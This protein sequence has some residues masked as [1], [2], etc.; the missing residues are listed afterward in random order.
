[1]EVKAD[2]LINAIR[3]RLGILTDAS[4]ARYEEIWNKLKDPDDLVTR[5]QAD[6]IG[7]FMNELIE[8]VVRYKLDLPVQGMTS[9]EV[10]QFKSLWAV[11]GPWLTDDPG[12][13][14]ARLTG[15]LRKA[16][17]EPKQPPSVPA[18]GSTSPSA[19]TVAAAPVM[20]GVPTPVRALVSRSP[21]PSTLPDRRCEPKPVAVA[22]AAPQSPGGDMQPRPANSQWV[23]R[24]VPA[25]EP[26]A[27]SVSAAA[28][29]IT[30]EHYGLL[31][32]RVRGKKHKHEGTN[33]DDWFEIETSGDWALVAVA[34]GAGSYKYSRIGARV[35]CERAIEVLREGLSLLHLPERP[36]ADGLTARD[37]DGVILDPD[38]AAIQSI[39]H[40]AV[41][42][43][44][45]AVD[46][47][48]VALGGELAQAITPNDLSATLLLAV[49]TTLLVGGQRQSL[50]VACQIGD[51]VIA[52]VWAD[53]AVTLLGQAD[54]G[55]YSGETEF[56]TS[57]RLREAAN[58]PRR[59]FA[60]VGA[61][62]AIL[63]MTDGVGD[64]YFPPD[65][66]MARLYADLVQNGILRTGGRA[67]PV[68]PPP[69]SSVDAADGRLDSHVQAPTTDGPERAE[70]ASPEERLRRWLDAYH[71]RGSFDDRTLVVLDRE[72]G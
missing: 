57:R 45:A 61:P 67:G 1:M 17:E 46:N 37:A 47:K 52:A 35:S 71:V 68:A 56:L 12:K 70:A 7:R 23:D 38:V 9:G 64:D 69:A 18:R 63:V 8:R 14:S 30:A 2:E 42:E 29:K 55:D 13:D 6:R 54:S 16:L 34:D 19:R 24:P 15:L 32:A 25:Q 33:C 66:G 59:T 41:G 4:T 10:E 43:A 49:H 28:A 62:R 22:S 65:P 60:L 58:L 39:L 72:R 27:H 44:A 40:R 53:D 5:A 36:S 26:H 21:S 11:L 20:P 48:A 50:V 51:G 31:G 3:W